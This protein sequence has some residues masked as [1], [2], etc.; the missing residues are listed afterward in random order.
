MAVDWN[1]A[2]GCRALDPADMLG[3]LLE[4]PAQF[5]PAY[6]AGRRLSLPAGYK[7]SRQVVVAGMGGSAIAGDYVAALL[8]DRCRVPVFVWRDYGLPAF[9]GP[10]TL[11]VASSYSGNTEETLSAFDRARRA[12]ARIIA[13]TTGGELGRRAEAAGYPVFKIDYQAP[14]RAALAYSLFP[15]LGILTA[16]EVAPDLTAEV[17]EA[18]AVA[19]GLLETVRPERP[20]GSNPAK[21]L[22]RAAHGRVVVV[23]G[24][25]S[26][27]P[28]ARRW[29]TQVNENSKGWAFFEA[30]PELNHNAVVGFTYPPAARD[31]VLVIGLGSPGEAAELDARLEVTAELL[32]Q[33]GHEPRILAAR[34]N[35]RLARMMHLTVL[36]DWFSYYLAL[37]NGV[38]P[39][40]VPPIDF[41]KAELARRREGPSPA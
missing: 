5:R 16:L 2:E 17:D 29:K 3:R 24:G 9:A 37:L 18:G 36:G 8:R 4:F 12:G 21:A 23:Y 6:D 32:R 27:E 7:H 31:T 15:L 26:L 35:S 30:L 25:G 34:G 10:D 1:S 38:D 13:L 19:A 40:P 14:P 33:A 20:E 39:T 11:V 22:A 41:L 28:V